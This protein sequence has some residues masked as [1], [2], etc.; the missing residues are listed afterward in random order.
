MKM[1][2]HI[3]EYS[4]TYV[5][6]EKTLV[7]NPEYLRSGIDRETYLGHAMREPSVVNIQTVELDVKEKK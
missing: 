2:K 4:V 5:S 1:Y 6:T 3:L 7:D